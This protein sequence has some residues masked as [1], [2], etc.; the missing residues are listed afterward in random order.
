MKQ[1][2]GR[3]RKYI[4]TN[5]KTWS[6]VLISFRPEIEETEDNH[7]TT[8]FAGENMEGEGDVL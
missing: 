2:V 6:G 1:S 4:K 5:N 3:P 7:R 8:I